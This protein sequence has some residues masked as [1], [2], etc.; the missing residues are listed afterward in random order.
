MRVSRRAGGATLAAVLLLSACGGNNTGE[1]PTTWKPYVPPDR[2]FSIKAPKSPEIRGTGNAPMEYTFYGM[3]MKAMGPL[4]TIRTA[5][6][7]PPGA[8]GVPAPLTAEQWEA[9]YRGEKDAVVTGK[10]IANGSYSGREIDIA[11]GRRAPLVIRIFQVN[12]HQYW[13]E[14]NPAIAHSMELADTFTIP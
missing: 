6:L 9:A 8:A 12:G 5:L 14:W 11:G 13:L 1:D 2:A 10:D 7:P 4:L 3:D